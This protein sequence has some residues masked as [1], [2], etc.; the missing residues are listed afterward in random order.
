MSEQSPPDQPVQAQQAFAEFER[1]LLGY[2][3]RLTGN[4]ET[5]RDVVQEVF[6]RLCREG[7]QLNGRMPQ[8]LFAVC[9]N[10]AIDAKRKGGRM[11][12]MTAMS[13]AMESLLAAPPA[14]TTTDAGSGEAGANLL[15]LL[16]TLS[17][18]QEEVIRLRM[19]AGLSYKQIAEVTGHSIS[20]VGFL[21]H[22]GLKTLREKLKTEPHP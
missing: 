14:S 8:W 9:R 15:A 1:P 11:T 7:A 5:A 19:G 4:A 10:L 21:M 20:N 17:P 12:T 18:H 22:A 6:L 2:A 3:A 16:S 13:P